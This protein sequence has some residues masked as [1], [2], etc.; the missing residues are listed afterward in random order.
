[1]LATTTAKDNEVKELRAQ[2]M[3]LE[4][5]LSATQTKAA[6]L[7]APIN[8]SASPVGLHAGL[9]LLM[10]AFLGFLLA[11]LTSLARS[12]W[13]RIKPQLKT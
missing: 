12:A 5:G 1:L 4:T 2:L 13:R 7:A 11:V 10:S 8:T 3:N 9:V 6:S